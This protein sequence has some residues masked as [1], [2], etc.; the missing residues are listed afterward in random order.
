M[1]R[2]LPGEDG[3][4][5]CRKIRIMPDYA[6]VPIVM[7]TAS[8]LTVAEEYFPAAFDVQL[9]KP[10]NKDKLLTTLQCFLPFEIEQPIVTLLEALPLE[11]ES[12]TEIPQ[13]LSLLKTQYLPLVNKWQE[14]GILD[15]DQLIMVGEQLKICA[16]KHHSMALK[17]WAQQLITDAELFDLTHLS[18]TLKN[19]KELL[20]SLEQFI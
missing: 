10:L 16:E 5:I 1:D 15:V 9:E 11:I 18:V 8:V 2:R 13:L 3:D 19:F 20:H 17:Q 7:I 12:A 6:N 4:A 14:S